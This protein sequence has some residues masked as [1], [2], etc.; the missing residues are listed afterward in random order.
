MPRRHKF[1][2]VLRFTFSSKCQS[3][4]WWAFSALNTSQQDTWLLM[5]S[6]LVACCEDLSTRSASLDEIKLN[7]TCLYL[8]LCVGVHL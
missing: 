4:S 1:N 7:L 3:E 2:P 5:D 6:A 8:G